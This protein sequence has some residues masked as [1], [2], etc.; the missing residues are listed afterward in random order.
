MQYIWILH[1]DGTKNIL[2]I[3]TKE[4]KDKVHFLKAR[5]IIVSDPPDSKI[6]DIKNRRIHFHGQGG[7]GLLP[8]KYIGRRAI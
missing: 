2:D 7:V 6:C 5:D 1:C 4:D 3:F 8:N